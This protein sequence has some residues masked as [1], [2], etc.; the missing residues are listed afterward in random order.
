MEDRWEFATLVETRI[1][2][3]ALTDPGRLPPSRWSVRWEVVSRHFR[4]SP[5]SDAEA[6][7]ESWGATSELPPRVSTSPGGAGR[8]GGPSIGAQSAQPQL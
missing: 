5:Q 4:A 7:A 3:R 6:E 8:G 2:I 1:R